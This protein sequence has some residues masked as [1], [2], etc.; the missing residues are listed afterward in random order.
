MR[1]LQ[2]SDIFFSQLF[3]NE[4]VYLSSLDNKYTFPFLSQTSLLLLSCNPTTFLL[5]SSY[6]LSFQKHISTNEIILVPTFLLFSQILPLLSSHPRFSTLLLSSLPLLSSSSL[7]FSFFL[8]LLFFLL[9][10]HFIFFLFLFF[11]LF[12]PSHF[13]LLWSL[14]FS[15]LF[16]APH[17]LHLFCFPVNLRIV[18]SKP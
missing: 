16:W 9:L 15:T 3:F 7:V 2:G 4:L 10:F 13:S 8:F 18:V 1:Q 17:H 12:L 5:A 14:L 6:L 11:F